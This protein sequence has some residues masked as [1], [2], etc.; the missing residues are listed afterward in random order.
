MSNKD[1]ER[2]LSRHRALWR[3][4]LDTPIVHV[5]RHKPLAALEIVLADGTPMKEDM[6]LTPYILDPRRMIDLEEDPTRPRPKPDLPGG[7]AGAGDVFVTRRPITRMCW[8][9]AVMGCPVHARTAS[10]SIYSEPYLKSL[11]ELDRI[12]PLEGNRW[13]EFLREYDRVLVENAHGKYH[14]SQCLMRSTVDQMAALVGYE[15]MCSAFY[16]NPKA[17]HRMNEL[18]VKYF[19]KVAETQYSVIPPLEGGYVSY[20]TLWAPGT[21]IRTQCDASAAMSAKTYE[22]FFFP[23]EEEIYRQYDYSIVH[24]HSGYLHTV[25]TFLKT[26]YPSAIQVSLDTGST[27]E[28][29]HTLLPIFKRILEKK[30]LIING[31]ITQAELDE[32]LRELPAHGLFIEVDVTD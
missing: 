30:P 8:V 18:S 25:P 5:T 6:Y 19:L 11:D 29:P 14:V 16:D 21:V 28:T 24:L 4:E 10:G 15:V 1:L 20:F 12:P 7:I 13:L 22:E 26:K 2:V 27:P 32:L 9:E 31:P 17:V 3:M 23:Y